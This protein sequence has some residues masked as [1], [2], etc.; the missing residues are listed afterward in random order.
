ML[1]CCIER[2]KWIIYLILNNIWEVYLSLL[3][4]RQNMT[5]MSDGNFFYLFLTCLSRTL[6]HTHTSILHPYMPPQ[7]RHILTNKNKDNLSGLIFID[8]S[9]NKRILCITS[10]TLAILI[11][12]YNLLLIIS[13]AHFSDTCVLL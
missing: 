5:K 12:L 7:A 3:D 10:M 4:I 9:E 2:G 8:I 11:L 6:R 1:F 13:T